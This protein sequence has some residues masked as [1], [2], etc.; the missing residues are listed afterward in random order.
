VYSSK[1]AIKQQL[2]EPGVHNN[3]YVLE[4][5]GGGFL[6]DTDK[7]GSHRLSRYLGVLVGVD[8]LAGLVKNVLNDHHHVN[9]LSRS[10]V[11][12]KLSK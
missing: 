1:D 4:E 3:H 11:G 2:N 8:D 6:G 10:C 5:S 12:Q 7:K 9:P